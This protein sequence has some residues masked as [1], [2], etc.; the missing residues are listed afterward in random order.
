LAISYKF[1]IKRKQK[2]KCKDEF[3]IGC[4]CAGEARCHRAIPRDLP[5]ER[6]AKLVGR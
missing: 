6:G 3:S 4:Y 1:S 5:A 2:K